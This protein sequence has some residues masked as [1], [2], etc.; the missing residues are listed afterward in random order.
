MVIT[1][2]AMIFHILGFEVSDADLI[3]YTASQSGHPI[4]L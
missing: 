3:L 4:V 1:A 2:A